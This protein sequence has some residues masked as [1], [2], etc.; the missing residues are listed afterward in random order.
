MP[1]AIEQLDLSAYD[2]IISSNHTV[3][4]GVSD[5]AGSI[6]HLLLS[7]TNPLCMDLQ[8]QYLRDA[9][10]AWGIKSVLARIALHYIRIWDART[11]N[12]VDQFTRNSPTLR[13]GSRKSM[14]EMPKSSIR[15]SISK[16]SLCAL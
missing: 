9:G 10:V 15:P 16:L 4:K 7:H 5:G 13:V 11:A 3:A 2:V 1:I 12:G 8:H 6:T 14:D